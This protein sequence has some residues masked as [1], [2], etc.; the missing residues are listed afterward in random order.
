M[1]NNQAI[2]NFESLGAVLKLL[3]RNLLLYP[4]ASN[5]LPWQQ[6]TTQHVWLHPQ[7]DP[8]TKKDEIPATKAMHSFPL[9]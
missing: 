8:R 2:Q 6:K 4:F 5:A 1:L 7:V 9:S 3:H